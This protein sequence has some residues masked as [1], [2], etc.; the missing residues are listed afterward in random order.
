[1]GFIKDVLITEIFLFLH[2]SYV[3]GISRIQIGQT[4]V[5]SISDPQS[6]FFSDM[7]LGHKISLVEK[8]MRSI[9]VSAPRRQNSVTKH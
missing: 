5:F 6:A 7:S 9:A 1:V 8:T 3:G 2:K 4:R